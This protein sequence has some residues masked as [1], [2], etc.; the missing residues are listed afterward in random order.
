MVRT[1]AR[2]ASRAELELAL[3]LASRGEL[4]TDMGM[5]DDILSLLDRVARTGVLEPETAREARRL[6]DEMASR[7]LLG[8]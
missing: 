7:D 4:R 8:G 6:H 2:P 1:A 3:R 5:D